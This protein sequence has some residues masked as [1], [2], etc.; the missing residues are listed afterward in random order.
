MEID[1]TLRRVKGRRSGRTSRKKN[2]RQENGQ[3]NEKRMNLE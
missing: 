2:K 1:E 3:Y